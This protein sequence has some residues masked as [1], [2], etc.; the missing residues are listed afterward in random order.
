MSGELT[1]KHFD[2]TPG[3]GRTTAG[4]GKP[5]PLEPSTTRLEISGIGTV[6]ELLSV[7]GFA[8]KQTIKHEDVGTSR[9]KVNVPANTTLGNLVVW[10]NCNSDGWAYWPKPCRAASRAIAL[11]ESTTNQENER[12]S[13][14]DATAAET[15]A[16]LK[17][18]KAFLTRQGVQEGERDWIIGA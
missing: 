11:I 7:D 14:E 2:L 17:P 12:R 5:D 9:T 15:T 18:I 4:K 13:R 16:A 1:D 6:A 8:F 10:T 3:S